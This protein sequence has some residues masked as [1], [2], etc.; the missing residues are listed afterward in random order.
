VGES[1]RAHATGGP[2]SCLACWRRLF[3]CTPCHRQEVSA[4]N[5]TSLPQPLTA[6]PDLSPTLPSSLPS[7]SYGALALSSCHVDDLPPQEDMLT[8]AL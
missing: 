8:A 7:F 1:P 3:T 4:V 6:C 2:Y 5:T